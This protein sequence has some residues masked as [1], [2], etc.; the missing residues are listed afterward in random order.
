MRNGSG[1]VAEGHIHGGE[2]K[3]I[4]GG[5]QPKMGKVPSIAHPWIRNVLMM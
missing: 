5:Q 2:N 4:F 1:C 3:H